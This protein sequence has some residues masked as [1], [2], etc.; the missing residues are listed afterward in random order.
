MTVLHS[1]PWKYGPYFNRMKRVVGAAWH[2]LDVWRVLPEA[3]RTSLGDAL[4]ETVV[5]AEL[6]VEGN[7]TKLEIRTSSGVAELDAE[8]LRAFQAS[9]PFGATPDGRQLD[10]FS[11]G[12]RFEIAAGTT[13][14]TVG[15]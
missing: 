7:I 10:P 13:S 5:A 11:F 1:R 9:S 12:F 8:A 3:R 6:S 2:P 15:P 4:R 14:M